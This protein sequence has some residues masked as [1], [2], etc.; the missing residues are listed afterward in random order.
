MSRKPIRA[1]GIEHARKVRSAIGYAHPTELPIEVLAYMRGALVRSSPVRGARA[2]LVRVGTRGIIGVAEG[3]PNEQRRFAIAHELGHF[4]VH[5]NVSW[6]GLCTGDDLIAGY[7]ASGREEEANAFATELLMPADLFEPGCD[8]ARVAWDAIERLAASFQ[9]SLSAAAIRFVE[10]SYERVAVVCCKDGRVAWT[11]HSA[12]FHGR[13]ERGAR[14]G[15]AT[16]AHDFFAKAAV[17]EAPEA[18]PA[19]AW[20]ERATDGEIIEHARAMPRLG[21]VMSLLWQPFETE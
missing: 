3:L 11:S 19:G 6:L 17:S 4:E 20:L 21:L 13:I 7:H 8:V 9:V 14:V 16:L 18:V 15:E 2:N 1:F 5:A 10:L 12:D